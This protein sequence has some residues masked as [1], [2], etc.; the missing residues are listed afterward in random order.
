M[1]E[2]NAHN[3]PSKDIAKKPKKKP[4]TNPRA[5]SARRKRNRQKGQEAEDRANEQ[6]G[7]E[8]QKPEDIWPNYPQME[9][10]RDT[11]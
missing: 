5:Q 7:G 11:L 1:N 2:V 10:K 4:S 9:S 8:Q 3:P 6:R